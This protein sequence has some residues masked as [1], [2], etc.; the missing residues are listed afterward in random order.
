MLLGALSHPAPGGAEAL[1]V[2][3]SQLN[4]RTNLTLNV[5]NTG[6]VAVGFVSYTVN[7]YANQYTKTN[8]TGPFLN[9]NQVAAINIIIDGSTFT[10]QSKNAYTIALTTT[11][12]SIFTFT[13]TA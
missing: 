11:R 7:Y 10:F 5:R 3:T 1:N 2:E 12:N 8:W 9:P 13:I 4:S 6:V